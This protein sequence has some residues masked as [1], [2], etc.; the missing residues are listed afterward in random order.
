MDTW[1]KMLSHVMYILFVQKEKQ[2]PTVG[3]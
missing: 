3:I 2:C 1:D